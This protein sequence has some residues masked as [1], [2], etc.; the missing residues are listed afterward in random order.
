[1]KAFLESDNI[2]RIE[3]RPTNSKEIEEKLL[4]I[5]SSMLA[6]KA[7]CADR[8]TDDFPSEIVERIISLC[9]SVRLET[10]D[11]EVE[12]DYLDTVC[13][14]KDVPGY[15]RAKLDGLAEEAALWQE[16]KAAFHKFSAQLHKLKKSHFF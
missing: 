1:M 6:L 5:R 10:M 15:F 2:L 9:E 7:A 8:S 12:Q 11:I 16:K 14:T 13:T 3:R 4:E